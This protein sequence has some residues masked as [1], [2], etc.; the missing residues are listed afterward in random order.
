MLAKIPAGR[1]ATTDEVAQAV[2]LMVRGE[3]PYM[4]GAMLV[5]DGAWTAV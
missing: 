4:N 1:V 3:L 5:L 2:A